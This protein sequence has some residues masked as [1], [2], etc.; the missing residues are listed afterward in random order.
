VWDLIAFMHEIGECTSMYMPVTHSCLFGCNDS[1]SIIFSSGHNFNSP[2]SHDVNI[3]SPEIDTCGTSCPAASTN[4]KWSTAAE[5]TR[6]FTKSYS[7]IFLMTL[8]S[9]IFLIL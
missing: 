9:N 8:H 6:E 4:Q 5:D 2:H 3:Y 1:T 7:N